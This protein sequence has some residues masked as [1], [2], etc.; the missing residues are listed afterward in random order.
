[1][2]LTNDPGLK[3]EVTAFYEKF[4]KILEAGDQQKYLTLLQR[5]ISEEAASTPWDEKAREQI[6]KNM[7]EYAQEKRNFIY[8]CAASELKFYGQGRVVTLVCLDT[9]TF[10]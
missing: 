8:P 2:P 9:L 5:S 4:K 7:L 1:Q 10:G 6:T 3:Q